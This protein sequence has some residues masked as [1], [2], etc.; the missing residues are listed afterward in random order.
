MRDS[1]IAGVLSVLRMSRSSSISSKASGRIPSRAILVPSVIRSFGKA[2]TGNDTQGQLLSLDKWQ[3]KTLLDA[4]GIPTPK[5]L[6]VPPG[7]S[8]PARDLF[9]GPYIVKPIQTDASEGIDK[10]SIVAGR[11]K[12]LRQ[13]V[14]R[15]HHQVGQPALIEQ[16]IEGRELNISVIYRRGEA[17]VLP[18][19]EIDFSAFEASRPRIVGYEAKWLEDSFEYLHTP[20]VI[21]AP[22][23]ERL[24]ERVRALAVASCRA[25]IVPRLLS[26]RL[27]G[28]QG[29]PALRSGGQRQP[30]HLA[31]RGF[32]RGAASRRHPVQDL[33][34]AGNRQCAARVRRY[35][36]TVH[37]QDRF[38]GN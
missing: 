30:G 8:L 34:Q 14:E 36:L 24:A 33:R 37:S 19:A 11:G 18:L 13:V 21:P 35:Q 7:Q 27:P 26:C 29:E 23:P 9:A 1:R 28:G 5:G 12:T 25:L 10:T 17:Q 3:S 32:R 31:R 38:G 6:I 22:L 20:R 16:Y 15:I 2:C 4:A